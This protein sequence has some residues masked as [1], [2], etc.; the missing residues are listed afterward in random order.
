MGLTGVQDHVSNSETE[1]SDGIS[2]AGSRDLFQT[3]GESRFPLH[4][5]VQE[6]RG[7]AGGSLAVD[8][9]PDASS[10][11]FRLRWIGGND[12]TETDSEWRKERRNKRKQQRMEEATEEEKHFLMIAKKQIQRN[13]RNNRMTHELFCAM[14]RGIDFMG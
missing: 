3:R 10:Q 12:E 9:I 2:D 6:V 7:C 8:G 13:R 5:P 14:D 1:E 4:S 11:S